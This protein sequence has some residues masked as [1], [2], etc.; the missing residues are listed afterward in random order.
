MLS[1]MTEVRYDQE[2][3]RRVDGA[4]I[5]GVLAGAAF[6]VAVIMLYSCFM[7]AVAGAWFFDQSFT[8]AWSETFLSLNH[9]GWAGLLILIEKVL[10]DLFRAIA[11]I[12]R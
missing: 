4:T 9:F 2:P 1:V 8:E 6:V 5:V 12:G 3:E 7:I 11:R 10:R